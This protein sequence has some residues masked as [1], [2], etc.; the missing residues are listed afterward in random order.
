MHTRSQNE[1]FHPLLTL[2]TFE[3]SESPIVLFILHYLHL[4]IK[5]VYPYN[6]IRIAA[7]GCAKNSLAESYQVY[8]LVGGNIQPPL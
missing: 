8:S 1:E 2:R 3:D 4:K 6:K 7:L 5:M